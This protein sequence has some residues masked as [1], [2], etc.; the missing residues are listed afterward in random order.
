V[1]HRVRSLTRRL[2][3]RA[4]RHAAYEPTLAPWIPPECT[5]LP[6]VL[7]HAAR[8]YRGDMTLVVAQQTFA[9]TR[10]FW[11]A[12]VRGRLTVVR[13]PGDHVTMLDPDHAPHLVL[14]LEALLRTAGTRRRGVG[15]GAW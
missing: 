8:P 14:Q 13:V 11:R 7:S 10:W 6:G 1:W 5:W 9:P 2:A 4:G 12:L 3:E 15:R